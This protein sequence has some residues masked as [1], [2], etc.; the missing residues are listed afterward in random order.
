MAR[1]LPS[2]LQWRASR[3]RVNVRGSSVHQ[4]HSPA[5]LSALPNC[6]PS[7]VTFATELASSRRTFYTVQSPSSSSV[8]REMFVTPLRI[9][10]DPRLTLF[11]KLSM[12]RTSPMPT[13][14]NIQELK[15]EI[16]ESTCD[17]ER[18]WPFALT[19]PSRACLALIARVSKGLSAHALNLC[20]G[21]HPS[22]LYAS[23]WL[24]T[25][26]LMYVVRFL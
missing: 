19:K 5:T 13:V 15:I 20:G 22:K 8:T 12:A 10:S 1:L 2:R 23:L 18:N 26:P 16:L 24:N 17:R 7:V 9:L 6:H 14:L 11:V 3:A 25:I 4:R 21:V